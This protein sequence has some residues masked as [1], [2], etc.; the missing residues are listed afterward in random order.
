MTRIQTVYNG[1]N[2]MPMKIS[3]AKKLIA[4]SEATLSVDK[5]TNSQILILN[6]EPSGYSTQLISEENY[7]SK[8]KYYRTLDK[9][10]TPVEILNVLTGGGLSFGK[11]CEFW[12]KNRSGKTTAAL[13]SAQNFL[14]DYPEGRLVIIDS[15]ANYSDGSRLEKVFDIHPHNGELEVVKEDPRVWLFYI[16]TIEEAM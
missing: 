12:G 1:I 14:A 4:S 11:I 3:K 7:M 9:I 16:S 10:R 8:K 2:L 15:E 5:E 13:G 6:K